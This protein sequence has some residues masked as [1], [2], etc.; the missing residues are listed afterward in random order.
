MK[1]NV[2]IFVTFRKG[3]YVCIV[4]NNTRFATA[5]HILTLLD[6]NPDVWLTSDWIAGSINVNAV[7][8]RKE[9]GVL[10]EEGIVISRKGKDGG[11]ML[12]RKSCDIL[13]SDI[14]R[15]V[16]NTD[17]LGKKNLN[18]N[19]ACPIGK[20]INDRL[21]SLFDE[22]DGLLFSLLSKKTL[23]DFSHQFA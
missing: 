12:N 8:V 10:Q 2:I 5:V 7:I 3:P 11:S 16:R 1:L 18:T 17:V 23:H 19:P 21:Q 13:L 9:L 22:T 4:M 14:Y 20:Q 6:H 15:I